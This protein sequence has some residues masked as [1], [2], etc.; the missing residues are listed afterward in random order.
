MTVA[1]KNFV[2]P[3]HNKKIIEINTASQEVRWNEKNKA[4]NIRNTKKNLSRLT[5]LKSN[6]DV[7]NSGLQINKNEPKIFGFKNQ[8]SIFLYIGTP[9]MRLSI[10]IATIIKEKKI[11]TNDTTFRIFLILFSSLE[12]KS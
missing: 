9:D 8:S 7:I 6:P 10:A 4:S 3:F 11:T 12:K 5:S 2:L 1:K